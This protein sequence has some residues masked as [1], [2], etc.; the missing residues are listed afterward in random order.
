MQ[1]SIPQDAPTCFTWRHKQNKWSYKWVTGV[2]APIRAVVTLQITGRG[3]LCGS[4]G[5]VWFPIAWITYPNTHCMTV[6]R[7]LPPFNPHK[8]NIFLFSP[9]FGGNDPIL[10][11]T[12]Q[13]G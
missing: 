11:T 2:I 6:W 4:F 13:W 12:F 7:I 3:P 5:N 8:L 1:I 9:L 10:T